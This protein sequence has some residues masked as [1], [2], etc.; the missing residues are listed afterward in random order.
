MIGHFSLDGELRDEQ[1]CIPP[2]H[3]IFLST[4][5]EDLLKTIIAKLSCDGHIVLDALSD[6]G[7]P[8]TVINFGSDSCIH[9]VSALLT[10]S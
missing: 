1:Y 4:G 6:N 8:S 3:H 7:M 2:T 9:V 10:S 5:E